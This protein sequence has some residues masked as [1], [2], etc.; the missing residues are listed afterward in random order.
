VRDLRCPDVY[1][2]N[3]VR[4]VPEAVDP[5]AF[6]A[7]LEAAYGSCGH[8]AVRLDPRSGGGAL[9]AE[10]LL[11]G[12]ACELQILMALGDE[13]RGRR[14]AAEI[15]AATAAGD[16]DAFARLKQAEFDGDGLRLPG[17]TWRDHLRRK[18]PPV[19]TW[20]ARLDGEPV[21]FFSELVRGDVALL[22]DLYV[23]PSV[24]RRGV[25]TA[26]VAHCVDDARRRGART[27]FLSA[28]ADDT[29]REM[30]ARMGFRA[31]GVTR[32]LLK[33]RSAA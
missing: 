17:A 12:F 9:E 30:Y 10:L 7:A 20:L 24:R 5:P 8:R 11:R 4:R 32:S 14:G 15:R 22:E 19:A 33:T 3:H 28:R 27:C 31:V 25:A 2:A 13:L 18:C 23:L 1:D 6:L 29:P 16:W 26:L 21:G